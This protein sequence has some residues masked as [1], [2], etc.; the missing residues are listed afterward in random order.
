MKAE[1]SPA[2]N[3]PSSFILSKLIGLGGSDRSDELLFGFSPAPK[4]VVR[5]MH[6]A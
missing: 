1:D 5:K 4:I 2:S 6:A 3:P